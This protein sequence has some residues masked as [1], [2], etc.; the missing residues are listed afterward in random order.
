MI[1]ASEIFDV[2][3]NRLIDDACDG[4]R[5]PYFEKFGLGAMVS[6]GIAAFF[7]VVRAYGEFGRIAS[8][9]VEYV[10]HPSDEEGYERWLRFICDYPEPRSSRTRRAS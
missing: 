10:R 2:S 6:L 7:E 3:V 1:L 5:N 9:F 8:A 4:T